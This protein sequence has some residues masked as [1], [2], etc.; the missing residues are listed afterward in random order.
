MSNAHI[1]LLFL[2]WSNIIKL[3]FF[4]IYMVNSRE[5]YCYPQSDTSSLIWTQKNELFI[6]SSQYDEDVSRLLTNKIT[7][8]FIF[9]Y[10]NSSPTR[11]ACRYSCVNIKAF[12]QK[13]FILSWI[14]QIYNSLNQLKL[15]KYA[16]TKNFLFTCPFRM[17]FI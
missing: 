14:N 4:Y 17:F 5:I 1:S 12:N 15:V 9:L 11:V 2:A 13:N 10:S 16:S 6:K 8:S 3:N 7:F